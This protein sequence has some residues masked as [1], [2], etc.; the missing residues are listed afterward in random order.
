MP[1]RAE[2]RRVPQPD[3]EKAPL[4]RIGIRQVTAAD[5]GRLFTTAL[6]PGGYRCGTL[7][8]E[9]ADAWVDYIAL[10]RL[11]HGS[12]S[13]FRAAVRKF[14]SYV[15]DHCPRAEQASLV[16]V[17]PD[18]AALAREWMRTLRAAAAAGSRRPWL[19][20]TCLRTLMQFHAQGDGAELSEGLARLLTAPNKVIIGSEHLPNW[21]SE[22]SSLL[23]LL[24]TTNL[25]TA[26]RALLQRQC[27]EVQAVIDRVQQ[28]GQG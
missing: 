4:K 14:A 12:A 6:D 19:W 1:R 11:G 2:Y 5:G 10:N 16:R 23:T 13:S 24:D 22:K 7:V 27:D 18:L 26:R 3:T 15:D 17:E 20:S 25:P 9:L 8:A 21:Q 28:D